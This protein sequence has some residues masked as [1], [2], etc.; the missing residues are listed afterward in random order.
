MRKTDV[1]G[2]KFG[3]LTVL[4]ESDSVRYY[5]HFRQRYMVCKCDCGNEKEVIIGN[6]RNGTTSSCGCN[7]YGHKKGIRCKHIDLTGKVFGKLT[8]LNESYY[9]YEKK[10]TFWN[11]K[12]ECGGSS[13]VVTSSLRSGNAK[14]CGCQQIHTKHGDSGTREYKAWIS[15]KDRCYN[16]NVHNYKD[17]GMRGI[18]VC[19][20]WL[21]ENDG[22]LNFLSDMGRKPSSNHSVDR[23]DVNGNYETSN[24]KWST[25]KEQSHNRRNNVWH[26]HNGEKMVQ[27]DWAKR[28]QITDSVLARRLMVM[29]FEDAINKKRRKGNYNDTKSII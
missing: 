27:T 4:R 10:L 14:S 1:T 28:L 17:Y 16:E 12:C 24:C 5:K 19:D 2:Q 23:V 15:M 3:M 29:S 22:Y 21:D 8:V 7:H 25:K 9:D 20:R 26:E 11:C 6:L 18:K 13:L